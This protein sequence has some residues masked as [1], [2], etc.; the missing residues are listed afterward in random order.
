MEP[1]ILVSIHL[2]LP[3]ADRQALADHLAPLIREA[4]TVGGHTVDVHL[5]PY[6]PDA[7]S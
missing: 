5:Q 1:E 4:I 2:R 7:E 6:D 3:Q